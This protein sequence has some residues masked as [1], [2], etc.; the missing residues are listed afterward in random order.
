MG[1]GRTP[2]INSGVSGGI[3]RPH[4]P[5][6]GSRGGAPKIKAGGLW[7]GSARSGPSKRF[8]FQDEVRPCKCA[9]VPG[10]AGSR[11][12]PGHEYAAS[13]VAKR[14]PEMGRTG[15]AGY[16]TGP[17]CRFVGLV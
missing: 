3:P 13:S 8:K 14:L 15:Q 7:S 11:V 9:R 5:G 17:L 10:S 2:R 1:G 16:Q 12:C 4:P 6:K